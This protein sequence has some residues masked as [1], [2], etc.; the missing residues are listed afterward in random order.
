MALEPDWSPQPVS[1]EAFAAA[2]AR[3]EPF[4]PQPLLAV[5]VSGGPDSMALAMLANDWAHERGGSV[6]AILIDHGLRAESE[7]EVRIASD[8]LSARGIETTIENCQ[9]RP[10]ET[11]NQHGQG[12][13]GIK[14]L[15]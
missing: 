3:F 15:W 12:R 7:D 13:R 5:A 11:A 6:H 8:A 1:V 10:Q 9:V 4:E 14:A 2:M